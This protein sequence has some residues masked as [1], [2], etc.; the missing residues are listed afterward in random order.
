MS[1]VTKDLLR[2][3]RTASIAA[4]LVA[5]A[6]CQVK[7]LYA[8]DSNGSGT[9]QKLA[10]VGFSQAADR[11]TQTVRN[12]LIFLTSGGAGE[13]KQPEYNLALTVT[14]FRQNVLDEQVTNNLIPGR[15]TLTGTYTFTRVSDGKILRTAQRRSTSLLDISAQEF[16]EMRAY[17]DA[18]DRAAKQL[19]EFIRGD[20]ATTLGRQ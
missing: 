13:S 2:I 10:S 8:V 3:G 6:G 12:E 14:S 5:L 18:E 4:V 1:N 11:V 16:A 17:R 7:P 9:G 20:I 15:V 19:A